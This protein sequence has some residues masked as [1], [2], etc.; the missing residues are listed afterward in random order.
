MENEARQLTKEHALEN[1]L[2]F[3][4]SAE[5]RQRAN[6]CRKRLKA[7][8]DEVKKLIHPEQK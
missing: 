7:L 6:E 4:K 2:L 1:A 5:L 3:E 8:K